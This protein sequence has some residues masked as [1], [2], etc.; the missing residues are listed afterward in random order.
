M[1]DSNSTLI[2]NANLNINLKMIATIY[3]SILDHMKEFSIK[4][5]K[6]ISEITAHDVI[7]EIK[8]NQTYL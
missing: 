5:N 2:D 6:P 1:K 4:L 8:L 3:L 7:D